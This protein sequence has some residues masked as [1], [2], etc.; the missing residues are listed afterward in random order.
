MLLRISLIPWNIAFK[1]TWDFL[2]AVVPFRTKNATFDHK[3]SNSIFQSNTGY[4]GQLELEVDK[5]PKR[6][7]KKNSG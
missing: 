6:G 2:L 4:V 1:S 7:N 5:V 3:D